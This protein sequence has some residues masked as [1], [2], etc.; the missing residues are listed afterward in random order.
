MFSTAKCAQKPVLKDKQ[1]TREDKENAI[2]TTRE[3]PRIFLLSDSGFVEDSVTSG[4]CL[5]YPYD[6]GICATKWTDSNL[7]DGHHIALRLCEPISL[8]IIEGHAIFFFLWR[9]NLS[10]PLY[11]C[12]DFDRKGERE[13]SFIRDT[14]PNSGRTN[15]SL[16]SA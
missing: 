10:S 1:D 9:F 5:C 2:T 12:A 7:R 3:V 16:P 8:Q 6:F 15:R 14:T 4:L 13:E 11:F